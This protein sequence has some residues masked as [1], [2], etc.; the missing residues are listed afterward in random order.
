MT[1]IGYGIDDEHFAVSLD[2]DTET[3]P[4]GLKVL[5]VLVG[6]AYYGV[7]QCAYHLDYFVARLLRG[8]SLSEHEGRRLLDEGEIYLMGRG[9]KLGYRPGKYFS[10]KYGSSR[11]FA[12]IVDARQYEQCPLPLGAIEASSAARHIAKTALAA[13]EALGL[14]THMPISPIGVYQKAVLW[15]LEPPTV[16]HI[17]HGAGKLAYDCCYGGWVEAYKIGHFKQTY[18][19][20][21]NSA[22]PSVL[23]S[24]YDLRNG[25]WWRGRT[26]PDDA[27]YGYALARVDINAPCHPILHRTQDSNYTP[28]GS[29]WT[30]LTLG[31]MR[32]IDH[33]HLG[34]YEVDDAWWWAPVRRNTQPLH[35]EVQRLYNL[36]AE[37]NGTD[38]EKR[39]ARS[40][41][42]RV[43]TGIY[44]KTLEVLDN[45]RTMGRYFNPVWAAEIE[46]RTR[47]QVAHLAL[48]QH[49]VPLH[50]TV[51]GI[52]TDQP[53]L[54][55]ETGKLGDWKLSYSGPSLVLGTGL[56][57]IDGR[58]AEGDFSLDYAHL[59]EQMQAD[60]SAT[61]IV[62]HK[63]S[64]WT[65][66]KSLNLHSWDKLGTLEETQR[67]IYLGTDK[68]RCWLDR[69]ATA[70]AGGVLSHHVES[71]PWDV[72]LLLQDELCKEE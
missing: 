11:D 42:K 7:T 39:M 18:D 44:G 8:I 46:T 22:Y 50:V 19:Y 66:A 1:V 35:D 30:T 9:Y 49:I 3:Y 57:A 6:D 28:T 53:L 31:A 72:S 15:T 64:P 59:L 38:P 20:D 65:L 58:E 10:V 32:F 13:Y 37:H 69:E 16:D 60:P 5:S 4:V 2:Y 55:Y 36:K 41:A 71:E 33:H 51:D 21:L 23:A 63:T 34:T 26:P 54:I 56:L 17:P 12:L 24:L 40:I 70:T 27:V 61:D 43:L 47:L 29:R 25:R 68:K 67:H 62:M 45:G 52:L 48:S 14:P